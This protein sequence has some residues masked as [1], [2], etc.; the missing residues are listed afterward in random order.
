MRTADKA[1][2]NDQTSK[3]VEE[4]VC[5]PR[6]K[7]AAGSDHSDENTLLQICRLAEENASEYWWVGGGVFKFEDSEEMCMH[8]GQQ[9]LD[10]LLN[11]VVGEL[12]LMH[13]SRI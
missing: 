9:I 13:K 2:I 4:N 10:V 11:D 6:K 5:R 3:A 7:E 12:A 8:F 1:F